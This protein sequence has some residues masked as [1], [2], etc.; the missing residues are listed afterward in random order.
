MIEAAQLRGAPALIN[1]DQRELALRSGLFMP[2]IQR[3]E[4][5]KKMLQ[6]NV[7][8]LIK[9]IAALD[10]AGVEFIAQGAAGRTGGLRVRLLGRYAARNRAGPNDPQLD[11]RERLE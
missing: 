8:S 1:I 4:A 6:R 10:A 5:G 2:I 3:M 7:Q 11:V 9:L